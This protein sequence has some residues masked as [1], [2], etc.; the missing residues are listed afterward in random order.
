[1]S[2]EHLRLFDLYLNELIEWNSRTNLTGMRER[3]R[4][5]LEL[6]L[7]SLVTVPLLPLSGGVLDVGS[8]AGF[9][10]IVIKI[11]LP[12]LS[13]QLVESNSKKANF[14]KQVIR[15]LRLSNV[16]VINKRIEEVGIEICPNGFDVVTSRALTN[17]KQL[18]NWCSVFLS[19]KGK[20]VYY[21]GS[22]INENIKDAEIL[23]KDRGLLLD[24]VIPY[25]LPG[26]KTERNIV[27]LKR[28]HSQE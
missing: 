4:M 19:T 10:A 6:F 16:E 1:L 22:G 2:E 20:L 26:M 3:S 14:L 17:L 8:G 18:V 12:G 7:D 13:L 21:S 28:S 23:I 27:V 15:L 5:I 25:H 24:R 9:P 11:L